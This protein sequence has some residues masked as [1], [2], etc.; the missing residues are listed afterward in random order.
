MLPHSI[1]WE[2]S[3]VALWGWRDWGVEWHK[4]TE[5]KRKMKYFGHFPEF[6]CELAN[7]K[8]KKKMFI[9]SEHSWSSTKLN[10]L[11]LVESPAQHTLPTPQGHVTLPGCWDW[12]PISSTK[13]DW[14][15]QTEQL[16]SS[17]SQISRVDGDYR[18]LVF[19]GALGSIFAGYESLAS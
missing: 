16:I 13:T 15:E 3:V 8:I 11:Y 17:R 19:R 10:P 2:Q 12:K 14:T 6:K 1:I 18:W 7:S 9:A 5:L 4:S